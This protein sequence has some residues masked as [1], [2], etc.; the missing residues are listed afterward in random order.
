[1][2]RQ[3]FIDL[4]DYVAFFRG[5]EFPVLRRTERALAEFRADEDNVSGKKIAAAVLD[6]PLMAAKLVIHQQ[7]SRSHK[8]TRDITTVDRAI[9]MLGITPFLARFGEL[10]TLEAQL[11]AHPQ[12]LIAVLRVIT[13]ARRAA[14]YARDFA[15]I[16]HDIDVEEITLA[17]LLHEVAEILCGCFAPEMFEQVGAIQREHEGIRS[18][19][20]Q[21]IV[22]KHTFAE[23]QF[24]LVKEFG[25]P[26][27]LVTLLDPQH[28]ETPR[29]RSVALACD[30]ARHSAN[31]WDDPALPDDIVAIS[32]LLRLPPDVLMTRLQIPAE[33][34]AKLLP[35]AAD[36]TGV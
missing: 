10:K 3:A 22:F 29:V 18:A 28:A 19:V 13:R 16:R 11:A 7:A 21:K 6:D 1:M 33:A 23:L 26:E 30:L 34:A 9:M 25:L 17:A 20:A 15:L 2:L 32:E 12:A 5:V 31:G 36:A 24:A 35:P 4:N 27:L 8:Q 14:R